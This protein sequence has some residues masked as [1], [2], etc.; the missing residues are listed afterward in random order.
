MST[1]LEQ[2]NQ[3]FMSVKQVAGYLHLNEKKVYSLVGKGEIPATKVTG[4]WMFPRELV[5]KWVLD[6]THS[7]L[8]RDRLM[9]AGSDDPF[10]HRV[11]NDFSESLNSK[12]VISYTTTTTRNGLDLLSANKVDICCMS[13]GPDRESITR[14]PS[15]LQQYAASS[16]WILIR[17]LRREQGL[18]IKPSLSPETTDLPGLFDTKYRWDVSQAGASSQRWLME[19]LSKHNLNLSQLNQTLASLGLREAAAAINLDLCD[20]APGTR[21]LA[22]E[23][24]LNF[25]SMGWEHLD[26]AMSR[27]IWFR[28]LFHGL[29]ER[30]DSDRGHKLAQQLEGYDLELCGN[31]IWGDD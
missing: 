9:I 3:V 25:I 16:N 8:L 17:G 29:I 18:M 26:F 2:G 21:A 19:V 22:N 13:W 12:A 28:H 27:D 23:F 7:G 20:I 24:H 6:S 11:I 10:L 30:I 4:K 5:D 31:L 14:H 1:R 15:L